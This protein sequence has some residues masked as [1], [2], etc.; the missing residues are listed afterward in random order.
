MSKNRIHSCVAT[1]ACSFALL[2]GFSTSGAETPVKLS[3]LPPAVQKAVQT[4]LGGAK[5]GEITRSTEHGK[6]SYEVEATTRGKTRSFTI[7]D[8][9]ELLA[10]EV[11]LDE[12]P[13]PVQRAI[14]AHVGKG[15]LGD[16]SKTTEGGVVSYDVEMTKAGRA[17]S[18]SLAE[19]GKLL[20]MQLFFEEVPAIVQK[21]IEKE[22]RGGQ[23]GAIY[24]TT[25]DGEVNYDVE[26][27]RSGKL[28]S[29]S[30]DDKGAVVYQAEPVALS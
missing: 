11:F 17:R 13:R 10:T 3:D 8:E 6:T 24:K 23:R 18:F 12:T 4:H 15:K 29:L 20:E 27:T 21:A 7:G 28:C 2:C 22:T 30:F 14:R 25:E 1:A 16:I 9:G 26:I 19:D 5:P